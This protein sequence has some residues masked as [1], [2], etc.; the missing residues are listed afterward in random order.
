MLD[1]EG[2]ALRAASRSGL[3]Y[4]RRASD[5]VAV[6]GGYERALTPLLVL[7]LVGTVGGTFAGVLVLICLALGAVENCP[8]A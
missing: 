2:M 1:G 6:G 8:E 5:P 4:P 7:L 3:G